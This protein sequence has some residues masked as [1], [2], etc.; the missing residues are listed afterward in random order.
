M[1]DQDCLVFVEV[2]FRSTNRFAPAV[3]TVDERK[4]Q[5]LARAA[6]IFLSSRPALAENK[7]RFDVIGI[8]R[9]ANGDTSVEWLRDAFWL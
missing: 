8:D 6:E 9:D 3:L 5:K 2:R 1:Q 7:V 4:Q